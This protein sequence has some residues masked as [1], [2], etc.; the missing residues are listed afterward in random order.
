VKA[1]FEKADL[2]AVEERIPGV[3]IVLCDIR[4]LTGEREGQ[5]E[6]NTESDDGHAELAEHNV[7][8]RLAVFSTNSQDGSGVAALDSIRG[9]DGHRANVLPQTTDYN[10]LRRFAS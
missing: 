1:I 3:E 6:K 5:K 9:R 4:L 7:L 2:G 8:H 10:T